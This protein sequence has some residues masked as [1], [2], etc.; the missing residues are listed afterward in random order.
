MLIST[1]SYPNIERLELTDWTQEA[2]LLDKNKTQISDI[3]R[4]FIN[5]NAPNLNAEDD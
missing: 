1:P 2:K 3:D 5:T 4:L